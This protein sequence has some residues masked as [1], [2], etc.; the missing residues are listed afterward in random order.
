MNPHPIC[1]FWMYT[2]ANQ[3]I[4][5]F[6]RHQESELL[7]VLMDTKVECDGTFFSCKPLLFHLCNLACHGPLYQIQK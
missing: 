5:N 4:D 3:T 7:N 2:N 1:S 6:T